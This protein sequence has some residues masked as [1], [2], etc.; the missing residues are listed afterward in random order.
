M[1]IHPFVFP[2]GVAFKTFLANFREGQIPEA[3]FSRRPPL[4]SSVY[5]ERMAPV[6]TYKDAGGFIG[7]SDRNC[8]KRGR[9]GVSTVDLAGKRTPKRAEKYHFGVP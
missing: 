8:P 9:S 6:L 2:Q 4:G 1:G 7:A 5:S 3:Q